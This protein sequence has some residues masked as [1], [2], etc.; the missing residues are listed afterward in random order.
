VTL[1]IMLRVAI[2]MAAACRSNYVPQTRGRV[3]VTFRGG[4]QVYMR[5]G[6][7]HE[8]GLWGSGLKDAVAGNSGSERAA[9]E[10]HQRVRT[11]TIAAAV[12]AL[13]LPATLAYAFLRDADQPSSASRPSLEV[14]GLIAIGCTVALVAGSLYA[15]S[16]EPYRWDAINQFNDA[17]ELSPSFPLVPPAQSSMLEMR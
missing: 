7:P 14:D 2:V 16:A 1:P 4:A 6:Q 3:V 15:A 8:H 5:D 10:Y 13:C 12:G 11:G 17:A 9:R